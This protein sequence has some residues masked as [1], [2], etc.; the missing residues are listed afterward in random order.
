MT[1]LE[2]SSPIPVD[3]GGVGTLVSLFAEAVGLWPDNVAVVF[4]GRSLTYSE[5]GEAA[6][7]VADR[8]R[9]EG[10]GRGSMVG[11][12][13]ERSLEMVVAV[14]GVL[15]AGAAYVPLD[16]EFPSERLGYMVSETGMGVVLAQSRFGG[17]VDGWQ[18]MVVDL[19]DVGGVSG[20]GGVRLTAAA[21]SVVGDDVAYV[22]YTS[23]STGR[24]KGV[25]I[26][27]RAILNMVGWMQDRFHL[28]EDNVFLEKNRF[29]FDYSVYGF[30]WPLQVGAKL[31]MARPGGQADPAYLVETIKRHSVDTTD[32]VPTSLRLF[33]D[34]PRASTCTSLRVVTSCGETLTRDLQDRFYEVLPQSDLHNLYGP[35]EAAVAVTAWRC[36]PG[37]PLPV[38][39]IGKP[40]A[41]NTIQI[42]DENMRA[43]HGRDV[44]EIYI[45]GV[46]VASGYA[47]RPDL[48]E[49]RFVPDP[50]SEDG[51]LYKTG[52]L[53]RWLPTGDIDFLGRA[54]HQIKI[55]GYRV[56]LGEIEAVLT[57]H[58]SVLAAAVTVDDVPGDQ[59]LNA[60]V[61][62][63]DQ[64]ASDSTL[65][66]HLLARLPTYMV[67]ARFSSHSALPLNS[68]GKVD[69]QL[70]SVHSAT[71]RMATEV[72]VD[73]SDPLEAFLLSVWQTILERTDI[74]PDDRF[75]E[76]GATSIHAASFVNE[77]QRELDEII[78]VVT[79]FTSP[80]V[81]EYA[82][83][84][85]R[86]YSDAVRRRFGDEL[87]GIE[88]PDER[89]GE[90]HVA[91][92]AE[93]VVR[94][95][96]FD[97]WSKGPRN[98]PATFIL[99]PP[100]SG[101]TLLRVMLAGHSE[102]FAAPELQLLGFD[103]LGERR[104]L[105]A[106]GLSSWT[107]GSVRAVME[108]ESWDADRSLQFIEGLEAEGASCKEFFHILQERAGRRLVIDKST[109]YAFDLE[110]LRN[111]ERGFESPRYIHLVRH[112][113]E[114][115]KSFERHHMDQA[116]PLGKSSLPGRVMGE[117]LWTLSHRNILRLQQE[118]DER[119]IIT[120]RF[121]DLIASPEETMHRLAGFLEI[122]F[123]HAL[124]TPYENVGK[125][126]VDGI[127][128]ASTPMG[129]TGFLKRG[130]I[131]SSLGET[132]DGEVG[133]ELGA[134]TLE[135]AGS[136]G[137]G[138]PRREST[139]RRR[140]SY[141]EA[142][143]SRRRGG[144]G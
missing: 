45:G 121:E 99:A 30:F 82:E 56:E 48:T 79:V 2:P 140:R 13:C 70:L 78:Y 89:V 5:L 18:V 108:L 102:L 113:F 129:D 122:E 143:R 119:R 66:A 20:D 72:S 100:R 34:H 132:T 55:R 14:Y 86:D 84:L 76:L 141:S 101:T 24:P 23:G 11:L 88:R 81:H 39:P 126:M 120:V 50:F 104:T 91:V 127:H 4:E 96:E 92:V 94:S 61:M 59:V 87:G 115:S 9:A 8:L 118:I 128:A 95:G 136:F 41:G 3:G 142:M 37:D 64:P 139:S 125:K 98:A 58:P 21:E 97:K 17:L 54:D 63:Q 90:A 35:T 144:S 46:Q 75:F 110:T 135:L 25:V 117:A 7:G 43:V 134:P 123:Q 49:E 33:L 106:G 114:M 65:R 112:P 67:P 15:L 29:S 62:W 133:I 44:G 22:I 83:F 74:T 103:T 1:L 19:D 32:F 51:I 57:E 116:L 31:V 71:K 36:Q 12:L 77:V 138:Q 27:H 68:S 73:A 6:L 130:Q 107:E 69:R 111:A 10:V 60:H 124:I 80:T 137:Y 109:T 93:L 40:M 16:P 131:D 105:L 47:N 85:K 52:D 38:V 53:A 26:G 42:L 28:G